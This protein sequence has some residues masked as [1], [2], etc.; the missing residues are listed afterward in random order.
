MPTWRSSTALPKKPLPERLAAYRTFLLMLFHAGPFIREVFFEPM[1]MT[2]PSNKRMYE[3][4]KRIQLLSRKHEVARRPFTR[5]LRAIQVVNNTPVLGDM[6][7]PLLSRMAGIDARV[8][9]EL[10]TEAEERR[11]QK[12]SMSEL[13]EE[14]LGAKYH[15]D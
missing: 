10:Y 3:A 15:T 8:L 1:D 4:F 14:A 13:A 12:M 9:V 6:L 7:G 5:F 2:D 11:A